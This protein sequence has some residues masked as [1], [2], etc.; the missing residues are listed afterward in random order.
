[1]LAVLELAVLIAP[2]HDVLRH[3]RVRP[4]T[5]VNSGTEAV[6]RSTQRRLRSLLLLHPVCGP[7]A[8]GDVMLIL[9]YADR[10]RIDFHQ[11][12]SGSCKRRAIE[13]APRSE[14]SRPGTPALPARK[15]S[16]PTR[17][18]RCDHFLCGHFRELLLHVE[19]ETSVSREAVPLPIATS[20]TLCF[21]TAQQQSSL[22]LR[23]VRCAGKWYGRYQFASGID[24]R[25]FYPS[26]QTGSRPIVARSPAGGAISRS[27]GYGQRR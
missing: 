7:V 18:L 27:C 23:L 11:L 14:T 15:P 10:F 6:L 8:S 12:P 24:H 3:L 17:Q 19:I 2:G 13:T 25:H 21:S 26:T 9:T 20:S 22:L 5:R 1:M 4:A 16:K